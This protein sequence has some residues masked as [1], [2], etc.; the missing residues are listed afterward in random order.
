MHIGM[1]FAQ[2]EKVL[3]KVSYNDLVSGGPAGCVEAGWPGKPGIGLMFEDYRLTRISVGRKAI[4]TGEGAGVGTSEAAL[5]RL[6]GRRAVFTDHP[7]LEKEGHYVTVRYPQ[8]NRKLI[9]ETAHGKVNSF[10][11]GYPKPVE[12]IEGCL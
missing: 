1:R 9:F 2:V 12:Y 3:G 10:R 4:T 6:Y 11:I 7:Y 5:R 8:A